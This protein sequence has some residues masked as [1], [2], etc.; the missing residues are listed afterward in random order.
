MKVVVHDYAGHPFSIE[1]SR[2]LAQRGYEVIHAYFAGDLGPKGDLSRRLTDSDRLSFVGIALD[3]PY[4]KASYVRRHFNDV[5]Y[6]KAMFDLIS[7]EKPDLVLSGNTP[8]EAQSAIMAACAACSCA[9]VFWIQDF[10]SIA[11]SKLLRKKQW[12]L[13]ATIGSYYRI[14]ERRQLR[15]SDS[16]V[17][18]TEQFRPLATL[19]GGLPNKVHTIENWGDLNNIAPASKDNDW[20]RRHDLTDSF[21]FIYAG[22]IGLKHNPQLLVELA[23]GMRGHAKVIV[24]GQGIGISHLEAAKSDEKLDNLVLLPLQ[25]FSQLPL[26]L[27]SADVGVAVIE[28]DAGMFSVPSKILSYLC[29]ERAVLIAAPFQ[30]LA[31]QIVSRE[32]AGIVVA[33]DDASA[34]VSAAFQLKDNSK[35]RIEAAVS[36]RKYA[37]SKFGIDNIADRFEIVFDNAIKSRLKARRDKEQAKVAGGM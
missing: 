13:G 22:T 25:H 19:W 2:A 21:N 37:F 24:V 10:Y 14:L 30:N 33:P 5:A 26:V 18:I 12:L 9:F 23:R 15:R 7:R 36:G 4:D 3:R 6:G 17:V 28:P 11:V 27:A 31:A 34:L 35:S 29:A 8:T 32:R 16:I 20:S 1:L